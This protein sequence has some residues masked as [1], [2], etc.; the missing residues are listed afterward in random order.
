MY[1]FMCG[2]VALCR[3]YTKC[4]GKQLPVYPVAVQ[5]AHRSISISNVVY[6]EDRGRRREDL[7]VFSDQLQEMVSDMYLNDDHHF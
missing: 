1:P 4:T 3:M 2:F 5:P 6:F 7:R